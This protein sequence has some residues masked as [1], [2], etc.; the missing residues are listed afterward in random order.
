MSWS[1]GDGEVDGDDTC[2][3]ISWLDGGGDDTCGLIS[4]LD[5]DDE[6]H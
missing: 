6:L 1:D 3:L 4:W 5:G 2:D